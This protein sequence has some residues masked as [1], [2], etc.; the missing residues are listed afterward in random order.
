M[1]CYPSKAYSSSESKYS[2]SSSHHSSSA[3]PHGH[4]SHHA[5]HAQHMHA[6]SGAIGGM[7]QQQMHKSSSSYQSHHH[8]TM[9]VFGTDPFCEISPSAFPPGT[10]PKVVQCFN[11]I[12]KDGNGVIDDTELQAVLSSC[13]QT[14]SLRTVHLLMYE[15]THSNKRKIG[16]KE[17][18]P[19]LKCLQTWKTIFQRFDRDRNGSIDSMELGVALSSQGYCV[20]PGIVKLLIA[21]FT[22]STGTEA[23]LGLS[24]TFRA[25]EECGK[26]SFTYEEFL[27]NVLPFIVA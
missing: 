26:A 3:P 15:F 2:M 16:P 18:V 20:S 17:F 25:R 11:R 14:F 10:D 22:K 23:N 27:L 21:N 12:D 7:H 6:P 4:G 8:Q 1:Q 9:T 19:L 13:N 5:H 24:E